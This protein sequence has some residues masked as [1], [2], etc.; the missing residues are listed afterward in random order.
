MMDDLLFELLKLVL[1]VCSML[2]TRY[3]IPL[4]RR[5][6]GNSEYAWIVD[7]VDD[8]V[9]YVEQITAEEGAGL[10][11]KTMVLEFVQAQ[12]QAKGIKISQE[13][14]NALIEATVYGLNSEKQLM[15]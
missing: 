4:I 8:A 10:K 7:V 5:E 9:R 14:L 13:Q 11:K 1:I 6:I 15:D 12:L 3:L 2:I